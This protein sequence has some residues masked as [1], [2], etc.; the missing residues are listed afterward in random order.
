MGWRRAKPWDGAGWV[1]SL[2]GG[3]QPVSRAVGH[4]GRC[5]VT[6][7]AAARDAVGPGREAA[8][9]GAGYRDADVVKLQFALNGAPV[10]ALTTV[11]AVGAVEASR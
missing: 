8:A 10:D 5:P 4:W 1:A 3:M 9:G 11:G 2:L 7:R 6:P